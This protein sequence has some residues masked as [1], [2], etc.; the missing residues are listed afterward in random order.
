MQREPPQDALPLRPQLDDH[1]SPIPSVPAPSHH[2]SPREA[3]DKLYDA[4]MTDL[5]TLGQDPDCRRPATLEPLDLQQ[6]DILLRLHSG[7]A[8][9]HLADT[10]E[11]SDPIPQLGESRVVDGILSFST[12]ACSK[13]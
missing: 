7:C 11:L 5:Q 13:H 9:R 8:G 12:P 4:V 10:Q 2:P 3:I 1:S 6:N